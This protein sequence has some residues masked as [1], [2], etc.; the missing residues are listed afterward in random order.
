MKVVQKE[1]FEV[2]ENITVHKVSVNNTYYCLFDINDILFGL[3]GSIFVYDVFDLVVEVV[4]EQ[5]KD[6]FVPIW[7]SIA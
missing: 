4:A 7:S 2:V 5:I 6:Y 1:H 3:C